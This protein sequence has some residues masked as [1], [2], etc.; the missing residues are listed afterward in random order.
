MV[1][2]QT[3]IVMNLNQHA[4]NQAFSPL[5]S[6]DI[7]DLKIVQSDWQKSILVHVSGTNFSHI[8]DL[9]K[10]TANNVNFHYKLN[11]EKAKKLFDKFKDAILGTL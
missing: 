9:C 3:L 6:R 10:N 2:K 8:W 5:C 7:S 11:S 1:F 4:K